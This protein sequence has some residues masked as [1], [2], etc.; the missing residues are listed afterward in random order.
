MFCLPP[1]E[2]WTFLSVTL[3][4]EEGGRPQLELIPPTYMRLKYKIS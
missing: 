3:N 4:K 2:L 1:F